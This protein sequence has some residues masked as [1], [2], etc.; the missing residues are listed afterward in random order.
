MC[1]ESKEEWGSAFMF[2]LGWGG[3]DGRSWGLSLCDGGS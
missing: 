1:I 3:M 2:W